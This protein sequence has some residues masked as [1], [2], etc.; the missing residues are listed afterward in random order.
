MS[1]LLVAATTGATPYVAG[2]LAASGVA[3][4]WSR[5]RELIRRWATWCVTAPLVGG[6]FLA[7]PA[8][9]ALLAGAVGAGCAL[10]LARLARLGRVDRA[11]LLAGVLGAVALAALHPS[12]LAR[13]AYAVPLISVLP[14]VLEGDG[15]QGG[16]RAATLAFGLLWLGAITGLVTLGG[17]A[18][19]LVVAVSV[20]DVAAW[21]AGMALRGPRLSPLSPGKRWSGLL[22]SGLA[23]LLVLLLLGAL[24]PAYAVAVVIAAPLG[25]LAESMVKRGAGVKDAGS[26]LPGFGG[27]LDR[28][29]SLLFALAVAV[30]LS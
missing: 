21:C 13:A 4:T 7:G 14:A 28:V 19:A 3:V 30:V 15:R 20:A 29:D 16:R 23:G 2:G 12:G 27:L 5:R 9:V 1:S 25:D 22:G 24:T 8:G 17:S 18:L 10:E 26:W 6:A 11:V